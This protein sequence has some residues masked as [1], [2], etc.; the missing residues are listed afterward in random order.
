VV[1]QK[2]TNTESGECTQYD[3]I[4]VNREYL[5]PQKKLSFIV[6]TKS[7]ESTVFLDQTCGKYHI[8]GVI[9]EQL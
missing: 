7:I 8:V 1:L 3:I 9:Y 4:A 5:L 6:Q 2:R